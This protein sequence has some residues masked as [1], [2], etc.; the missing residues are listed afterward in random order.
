LRIYI[1]GKIVF[2]CL[3]VDMNT[4]YGYFMNQAS[5]SIGSCYQQQTVIPYT[6]GAG[7]ESTPIYL[8]SINSHDRAAEEPQV[9]S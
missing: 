5:E 6:K 7:D 9:V 1:D 4:F 8:Q 3:V 2:F